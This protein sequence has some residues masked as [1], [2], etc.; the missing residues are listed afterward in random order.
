MTKKVLAKKFKRKFTAKALAKKTGASESTVYR[1]YK[2]PAFPH[3]GTLDKAAAFIIANKSEQGRKSNTD[4]EDH[5]SE[6]AQSMRDEKNL[7]ELQIRKTK[8][9]TEQIKIWDKGSEKIIEYVDEYT[10][11]IIEDLK[12]CK[13]SKAQLKTLAQCMTKRAALLSAQLKG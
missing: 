8:L 13:L 12:K 7:V 3:K 10:L 1:H 6:K 5:H 9:K 2:D 11:G 4:K